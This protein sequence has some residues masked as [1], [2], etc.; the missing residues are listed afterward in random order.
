MAVSS[1]LRRCQESPVPGKHTLR[2][3]LGPGA[4]A[5]GERVRLDREASRHAVVVLRV[6]AGQRVRIFDGK[7]AEFE[8]VIEEADPAGALVRLTQRLPDAPGATAV[9]LGFAPP[10]GQRTDVLVEKAAELG[11][12][13]LRP[14]LCER[15]QGFQAE[16]AARRLD[17]WRRKA[18]E[19]ARQSQRTDVPRIEQPATLAEFLAGEDAQLK[20]VALVEGSEPLWSVLHTIDCRPVDVSLLVG[21][22][23]G[24]TQQEADAAIEAGYRAV[25]LGPHT[26]RT[27]T[28]ALALLAGVQLWRH[29]QNAPPRN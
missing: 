22:A 9:T 8:G 17:R 14:V 25:S 18:R 29:A 1:V 24:F 20:L 16:A 5:V 7:G 6:E 4:S 26:L 2:R 21:P 27:E 23:G 19:A 28:A 15:L 10:P 13:V 12:A 11:T 3:F